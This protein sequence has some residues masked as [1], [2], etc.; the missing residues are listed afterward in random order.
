MLRPINRYP[1]PYE[2]KIHHATTTAC[3]T[4]VKTHLTSYCK[5]WQRI[6][7]DRRGYLATD[8]VTESGV[9]VHGGQRCRPPFGR[10]CRPEIIINLGKSARIPGNP[11]RG[12][13]R[14]L[15]RSIQHPDRQDPIHRRT[16]HRQ[17]Q[18]SRDCHP[19]GRPT[20]PRKWHKV[21][22]WE[23]MGLQT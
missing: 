3:R 23:C 9:L 7:R 16:G 10:W 12:E 18:D 11:T 14:G 21:Q 1:A 6:A 4:Q 8:E 15:G 20:P 2:S 5:A 22:S 13:P 19:N 17:H